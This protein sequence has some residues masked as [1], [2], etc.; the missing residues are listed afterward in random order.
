MPGEGVQLKM[1]GTWEFQEKR[2]LF[3]G[4]SGFMSLNMDHAYR[5]TGRIT[6][7]LPCPA[8]DCTAVKEEST[9][10]LQGRLNMLLNL[11]YRNTQKQSLAF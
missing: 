1:R 8:V 7:K 9:V 10:R 3:R 4:F 5:R 2:L 6:P 11:H